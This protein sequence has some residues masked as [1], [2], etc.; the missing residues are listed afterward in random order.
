MRG[1]TLTGKMEG[2][3]DVKA[4]K[5]LNNRGREIERREAINRRYAFPLLLLPVGMILYLNDRQLFC[6]K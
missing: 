3:F 2:K 6:L 4:G 5:I 1:R